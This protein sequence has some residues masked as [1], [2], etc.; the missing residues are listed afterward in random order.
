MAQTN[1][2]GIISGAATSAV[3]KK[4]DGLRGLVE[5]MSPE[6]AKALP[7]VVTPERFTRIAL[8]ALSS[9][10]K[11]ASCSQKSFLGSLMQAAQLG[12]EPNTPLGQA[13]LIPYGTECQ[14]QLGYRGILDLVH[15]SGDIST[16][17]AYTV[18]ENDTFEYCFGLEPKLIHKPA[19]KDRG[20]SVAYYA[21]YKTKDGGFGFEVMHRE[22]VEKHAKK[23]SKAF[24][25]GPWKDHF[26][27]MAKKTVLKK[28]LKYAP[29]RTDFMRAMTADENSVLANP[30]DPTEE[31][32]IVFTADD[33]EVV[34][35]N[36]EDKD[37]E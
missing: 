8:T 29:V 17:G 32:E 33:A 13:Y 5:R 31:L 21:Y 26:D 19:I 27:E 22:D 10:P 20:E 24:S 25:Y 9:N 36:E 18:H 15:R 7:S 1:Q 6:I 34:K 11:L 23:F 37:D 4:D 28:A 30:D 2:Q 3:R 16:V 35:E 12:L 14:F